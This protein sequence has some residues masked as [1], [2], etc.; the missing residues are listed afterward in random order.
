MNALSAND[1]M[2]LQKLIALIG[3]DQPGERDAAIAA[4]TRLLDRH[5]IRWCEVLAL[6]Q[7]P[8]REP[9]S[10]PW[11]TTCSELAR[12]PGDLRPWERRFVHDLPGFPRISSKQ[13]NV[14][15]QIAERVFGEGAP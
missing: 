10:L 14:L 8:K 1:R 12:R 5:G 7:Q 6:H 15:V 4:A 11:R 3:S 9:P 2:R 13:R